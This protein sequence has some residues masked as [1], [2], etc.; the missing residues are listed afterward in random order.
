MPEGDRIQ[1]KAAR[2]RRIEHKLYNAPLGLRVVE[3]A[4]ACGVD[5]RT[6]YRDLEA[7]EEMGVPIWEDSGRYSINRQDYLSTV[8]L[9]LHETVALYFAT[10]LL[11][12][13]SDEHNPHV[14]SAL[15]KIA[16]ALP[17]ETISGHLAKTAELIRQRPLRRTYIQ[18]LE[19][20][21]RAWADR[22]WV[23]LSYWATGREKAEER[24]IATYFL[25]VSRF[26]PAS[27]LIGYDRLRNDI[28][29]FKLERVQRAEVLDESYAVPADFD[30]HAWLAGSW[31]IM[32]EEEVEVALRFTPAVARRVKESHW[33]RSQEVEDEPDGGCIVRLRVGGIREIRSWILGWGADVEVLS[34]DSLRLEV[35]DQSRRMA[36][37]YD[38]QERSS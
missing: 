29:T 27:Y 33:H 24:T 26:E 18:T 38:G 17:D 22:R 12:H 6:I 30:P 5:R 3:L 20:I 9:N 21:T 13:H 32:A 25:E 4:S 16:A 11:A 1:S 15:D 37:H 2:L 7:L 10:R 14:V 35:A 23:Q 28:R 8:R 34:P 19:I 36:L 31:G